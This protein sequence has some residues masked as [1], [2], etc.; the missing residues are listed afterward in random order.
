[1]TIKRRRVQPPHKPALAQHEGGR[2]VV[3]VTLTMRGD[4]G[5]LVRSATKR[6]P[7]THP[8]AHLI[9]QM[10]GHGVLTAQLH[11]NAASLLH[12]F[13][14]AGLDPALSARYAQHI[15]GSTGDGVCWMSRYIAALA[16]MT[17][18][19]AGLAGRIMR[20]EGI[21]LHNLAA[22]CEGLA[23]LDRLAAE[24]DVMRWSGE[25]EA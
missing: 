20:G 5:G 7:L 15:R 6:Q 9:D 22:L 21:T 13:R 11:H 19:Q 24:Y 1:M 18:H 12:L 23:R 16:L 2:G 14:A 8:D 25:D 17:P 10:A 3:S 4:Q